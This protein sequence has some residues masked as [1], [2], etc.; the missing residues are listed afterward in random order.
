MS[1]APLDCSST[2]KEMID[3]ALASV[4]LLVPSPICW[5]GASLHRPSV[6]GGSITHDVGLHKWCT[7]RLPLVPVRFELLVNL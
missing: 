3:D 1:A 7:G 2:R 6:A 4:L 5:L